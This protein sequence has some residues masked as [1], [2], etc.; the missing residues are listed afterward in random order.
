MAEL[1]YDFLQHESKPVPHIIGRGVLPVQSKCVIGGPPKANKSF[2]A[3]NMAMCMAQGRHIFGAYYNNG[4]PVLP[5]NKKFRVLYFEQEIGPDGLRDR[6]HAMTNGE[7]DPSIE[8]FIKSRDMQMRLDMDSGRELIAAECAEVKPDVV[9][10]DPLAKFHLY[11]ENSAQQMGAVMRAGDKLVEK[12]GTAIIY[13]HH[14][15]KPGAEDTKRGGDRLRGS[16]AV[17][18]DVDTLILVDRQGASN[19]REPVIK[20]EMELRRGEPIETIYLKR[21]RFG[22]CEYI[23]ETNRE[24]SAPAPKIPVASEFPPPSHLG[25]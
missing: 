12:F 19:V 1:L 9:I 10:F 14:T 6:L 15:A 17:F 3:L 16:S 18:A 11:D 20:L 23:G 22:I 13:I 25:L 8:L 5:C 4:T 2:V 21:N 7:L 24:R